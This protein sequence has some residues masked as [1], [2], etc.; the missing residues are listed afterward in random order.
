M[1]WPPVEPGSWGAR[2]RAAREAKRWRQEDLAERLDV[3]YETVL[4]WE[5]N[6]SQPK[7]ENLAA[8]E[9]LGGAF[10][11]LA[12]EARGAVAGSAPSQ[13]RVPAKLVAAVEALQASVEALEHRV[14]QLEQQRVRRGA[15]PA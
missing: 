15:R 9:Q 12:A 5:R 3:A 4:K 1:T 6:R 7:A 13:I 14:A 10:K 8:L 11:A 2:L